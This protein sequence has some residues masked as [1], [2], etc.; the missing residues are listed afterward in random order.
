MSD[1]PD[2][3]DYEVDMESTG[4][5]C[6]NC[7]LFIDECICN[8]KEVEVPVIEVYMKNNEPLRDDVCS[9]CGKFIK[10]NLKNRVLCNACDTKKRLE[11]EY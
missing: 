11:V 6:P 10:T 7:L 3:S 4:K 5:V 8:I 2:G 9:N 1:F